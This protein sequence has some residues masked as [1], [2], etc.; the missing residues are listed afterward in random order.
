MENYKNSSISLSF[1]LIFLIELLLPTEEFMWDILCC[2]DFQSKCFHVTKQ[3]IFFVSV[4]VQVRILASSLQRDSVI[5]TSLMP[6]LLLW[7]AARR[8]F[9][10][11]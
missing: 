4:T 6:L 3:E 9:P 8:H 11:P 5:G 7:C 2:K 10:F 1:F